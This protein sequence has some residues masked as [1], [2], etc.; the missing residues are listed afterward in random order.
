MT[1]PRVAEVCVK[2]V[3]ALLKQQPFIFWKYTYPHYTPL[4]REQCKKSIAKNG[5]KILA[6]MIDDV[7]ELFETVILPWIQK[8]C[9][10]RNSS[11][12]TLSS[13][14]LDIAGSRRH[15]KLALDK[16]DPA[17]EF[18]DEH[19]RVKSLAAFRNRYKEELCSHINNL[20]RIVTELKRE[21]EEKE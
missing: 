19:G 14:D 5:H 15:L 11:E 9:E 6:C 20:E 13:I 18:A 12:A 3:H 2:A 8:E 10:E 17:V 1:D 16:F 4:N 7:E 21:C